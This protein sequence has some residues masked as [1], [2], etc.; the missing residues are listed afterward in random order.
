MQLDTQRK[1]MLIIAAAAVIVLIGGAFTI[2]ALKH[3]AKNALVQQQA[4]ESA[5]QTAPLATA[6]AIEKE[7]DRLFSEG[8]MTAAKDKY[9]AAAA[10]YAENGDT[11]A[12]ERI[13]M[14]LSLIA[15]SKKT[16]TPQT[17]DLSNAPIDK[18][19]DSE[20]G[21]PAPIDTP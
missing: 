7:A 3:Q 19:L 4:E 21:A 15:A 8:N 1:K 13:I 17:T 2:A 14:Q 6:S 20:R 9:K 18:K 16:D 10:I 5:S 11:A 12:G